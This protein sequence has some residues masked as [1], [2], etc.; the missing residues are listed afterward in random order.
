MR[1]MRKLTTLVLTGILLLSGLGLSSCDLVNPSKQYTTEV[2]KD[3]VLL[4]LATDKQLYQPGQTVTILATVENL[5]SHSVDYT[6]WNIGDPALY[7]TLAPTLFGDQISLNERNFRG[8]L[9]ASMVTEDVLEADQRLSREVIW[10]QKLNTHPDEIQAPPGQYTIQAVFYVGKYNGSDAEP[11][12]ITATLDIR[13]D[14]S[15][16]IITP[17]EG[18]QIALTVPEVQQWYEAHS[19]PNLVKQENGEYYLFLESGWQS[20]VPTGSFNGLSLDQIQQTYEPSSYITMENKVWKVQLISSL[21]APPNQRFV[22]V[23]ARTGAIISV[24]EAP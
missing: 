24:E 7:I 13:I 8:R 23:D 10:N 12:L 1:A 17:E 14:G 3:D 5:S 19:G 22:Q 11:E 6:M 2:I 4:K 9:V 18:L 15:E 16:K 21:G 20:V